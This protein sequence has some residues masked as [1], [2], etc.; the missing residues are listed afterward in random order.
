MAQPTS[1]MIPLLGCMVWLFSGSIVFCQTN[2]MPWKFGPNAERALEA[3]TDVLG[4]E[5]LAQGEP[6]FARVARYFPPMKRPRAIVGVMEHPEAIG[7][8]WDGTLELGVAR[9]GRHGR[10]QIL[11]RLGEP[12]SPYSIGGPVT[13]RLLG[14]YLPVVETQWPFE[15]L[16][17]EETVFGYSQNLSPEKPLSA[18]IRLRV[19]NPREVALE[20]HITVYSAPALGG[21]APSYSVWI[22]AGS[23]HDF[24]FKIPYYVNPRRLISPLDAAEFGRALNE[25]ESFWKGLLNQHMQITLP[26]GRGND[27]YRAWLMYNFLNV[28]KINGNYEIHDGSGF[29]EEVYGYS[30]ALYCDALSRYGYWNEAEKYLDDM[31]KRQRPDGLYITV[32]GLPDNGALLFALAQQYEFSH[33]LA[34]FKSVAPRMIK[35]CEWISRRRA[36]TKMIQNGTKPLTY[37][38]LPPGASY[39]DYQAPVY[40]YYSDSYNWLGMHEAALAF[41]QAGMTTEAAKWLR[42]ANDYRQDILN[43]MQRAVVDV[44]GI[45]ALPIEPLT[46]RLLKQGGGNYYGLTAPEILETRIFGP[47]DKR[48]GWITRYMDERGGLLLG[49]DRF[50]DGVDHAYTYGYALTQLRNGNV[51]KFLLTFYSMLAYG[52]SRGTYSSVE[53]THLPYGINEMTLPHTYSDTQQLRMLRLMFVRNEGNDLLLA[54]GTPRAWLATGKSIAVNR[55][56]TRYGLLSYTVAAVPAADQVRATID[57][58]ASETGHYPALVK[59]WLRAAGESNQL[60]TVTVNGKPWTSFQGDEIDLPGSILGERTEIVAGY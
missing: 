40:S 56:P 25:T 39:N 37:G 22:P 36:T 45:K 35:S 18:Y 6:S 52:M 21:P 28:H 20:A 3:N 17:Y 53:V 50:A 58:L 5:V 15:G 13:R 1:R 27:A 33:D 48:T 30:A 41:Q 60:K 9:K 10:V 19:T 44:D 14:G 32:F 46:Q 11:F 57:P 7:V 47:N 23:H 54:S 24:Y 12:P 4:Q 42:E 2:M 59:L 26:E 31:L 38:L 55:A 49:L 8:E 29:Y 43:S 34:W 16:L 51:N